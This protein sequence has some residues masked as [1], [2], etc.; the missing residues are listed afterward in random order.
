M[1]TVSYCRLFEKRTKTN[2]WW[3]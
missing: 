1:Q 3:A 2:C